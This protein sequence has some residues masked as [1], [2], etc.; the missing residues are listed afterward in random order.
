MKK[1]PIKNLF[2]F[3][4]GAEC[5][6]GL[7]T[8]GEFVLDTILTKKGTLY[9]QLE[10]IYE[11]SN[12]KYQKIFLFNSK[13]NTLPKILFDS[14]LSCDL[15]NKIINPENFF[16][17][18]DESILLSIFEN[19]ESSK[20]LKEEKYEE[21]LKYLK[22]KLTDNIHGDKTIFEL[23]ID[24]NTRFSDEFSKYLF[25]NLKYYGAIEKDFSYLLDY[26]KF[27]YR[28]SRLINY[29]WSC[30]FSVF[31]P[32]LESYYGT[33]NE[34]SY[35]KLFEIQEDNK[36]YFQKM[37][38]ELKKAD[39]KEFNLYDS[40]TKKYYRGDSYYT[41]ISS[42]YSSSIAITTNYTFFVKKAFKKFLYLSGR[43]DKFE[44]LDTFFI[45]EEFDRNSIP[46][47]YTQSPV[48]PLVSS[49]IINEYNCAIELMKECENIFVIGYSF[50]KEDAHIKTIFYEI[51]KERKENS[52]K[53]IVYCDYNGKA[54]NELKSFLRGCGFIV[55]SYNT[56]EEL[57]KIIDKYQ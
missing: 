31:I 6:Y 5:E 41:L 7:P 55:E 26:K 34:I 52:K 11:K 35:E 48:K 10:K 17:D 51:C 30:Y 36:Y 21:Y 29:F 3:G 19:I 20:M 57:I 44:N 40:N 53:L 33:K 50:C 13:S 46:F 45:S 8:G 27:S 22:E 49:Q 32:Y 15:K 2:F 16:S 23:L 25:E 12:V 1:Q 42:K 18:C 47:L 39:I 24:K 37:L 4:A 54:S 9:E 28:V 14:F 43:L 38:F 56:K